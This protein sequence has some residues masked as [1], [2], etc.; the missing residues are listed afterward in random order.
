MKT[1]I[2]IRK[3]LKVLMVMTFTAGIITAGSIG[4]IF[5]LY[6]KDT[7]KATGM[8]KSVERV[9]IVSPA[10]GLL[11][12]I[13]KKE[14][15][16][17]NKG[18]LLLEIESEELIDKLLEINGEL[19]EEEALLK[20]AQCK[21]ALIRQNPLPD[22]LWHVLSE[23][24][25]NLAKKKKGMNDLKRAA[26]LFDSKIISEKAFRQAE[27]EYAR[28]CME[29]E[30]CCKLK[31]LIE[32][33]LAENIIK[34]SES[35]VNLVE[36]RIKILKKQHDALNRKI[37]ACKITA[38]HKGV[39]LSIPEITGLYTEQNTPLI[40]IVWGKKKFIRAKIHEKSIQ[41]VEKNQ[42]VICYS[43][44]YDRFRTG[45]FKG[46]VLRIL[47]KVKNNNNG[48]FY[49]VDISLLEEPKVLRLGST[50]DVQIVTGRKTIF[51]AM[52]KNY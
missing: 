45:A 24:K 52:T 36:T 25:L 10:N 15:D 12:K 11:T 5:L 32:E 14:G 20:L 27:L 9:E 30:K 43:A 18:D 50:V 35:E 34:N 8:V 42:Y 49:E 33:G 17:V 26:K 41:D 48:R 38:P 37:T 1:E 40:R 39:I 2:S 16:S 44:H 21:L 46:K 22:K 23:T 29:Y 19:A 6:M 47:S 13:D 51:H 28:S 4:L 31:K 3:K 7:V